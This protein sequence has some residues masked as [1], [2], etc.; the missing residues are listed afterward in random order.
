MTAGECEA[1]VPIGDLG[2]VAHQRRPGGYRFAAWS[3]AIS[4]WAIARSARA[5]RARRVYRQPLGADL[6]ARTPRRAALPCPRGRRGPRP[7]PRARAR[8]PVCCGEGDQHGDPVRQTRTR[9]PPNRRH[10]PCRQSCG[11]PTPRASLADESINSWLSA[12]GLR[13]EVSGGLRVVQ[14]RHCLCCDF[15]WCCANWVMVY[16][17]RQQMRWTVSVTGMVSAPVATS[18]SASARNCAYSWGKPRVVR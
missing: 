14:V 13:Y 10:R 18:W 17:G 4:R 2:A 9:T 15:R 16:G 7:V 11:V 1:L 8:A 6:C 5:E 12:V 3:R